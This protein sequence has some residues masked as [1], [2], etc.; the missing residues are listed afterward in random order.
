MEEL[1]Q[2]IYYEPSTGLQ[3]KERL[4]QKAKIVEPKITRK[5]VGEF[6][7]KQ[8]TAQITKPVKKNQ[9]FNSVLSYGVRQNYQM[10][11]MY[12][13]NSSENKGFKYLL[14]C[15]DVY[16]R[17]VFVTPLKSKSGEA[18]FSAFKTMMEKY[19]KPVNLNLDLGTEFTS[20]PFKRY[21]DAENIH[22]WYSDTEQE[23]KNSIIERFHRTLRNLILKYEVSFGKP[24]IDDLPKLIENYNST[25]HR[26]IGQKPIDIWN[27]EKNNNQQIVIVPNPFFVG[28]KVRHLVKRKTF[29]KA[30]DKT[31]FTKKIFTIT[32][33]E[34]KAIYLDDLKK[35][36]R[37]FEL[38]TAVSDGV[39]KTDTY[40]FLNNAE[41][42]NEA[43]HRRMRRE[44][45]S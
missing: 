38:E 24:Y 3:S 30:S 19:G 13:P 25:I 16:S 11:I 18:V 32:K 23:N 7:D 41:K 17:Y 33:I 4:Y 34:G 5:I 9:V 2:K 12:L 8:A 31:S 45:I 10:D 20:L 1:L 26:T 28:D 22:L 40:D 14:T 44:G 39:D 36:F 27:G 42:A 43:F 15:I 21:C 29:E 35:P 6:Y 37:S